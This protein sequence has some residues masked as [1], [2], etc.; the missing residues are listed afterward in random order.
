[1]VSNSARESGPQETHLF[2]CASSAVYS[3]HYTPSFPLFTLPNGSRIPS[4][5]D[6]WAPP[7]GWLP[8]PD[9]ASSR[10]FYEGLFGVWGAARGQLRMHEI[11]FLVFLDYQV[12][13]RDGVLAEESNTPACRLLPSDCTRPQPSKQTL[14]VQQ[15]GCRAWPTLRKPAV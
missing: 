5:H 11:D 3:V 4:L 7:G 10:A 15:A 6:D 8:G 2:P 13:G 1:M 12:G 14:T 9:A